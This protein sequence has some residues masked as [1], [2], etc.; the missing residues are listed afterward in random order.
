VLPTTVRG[1]R[2]RSIVFKVNRLFRY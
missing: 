2:N 1:I